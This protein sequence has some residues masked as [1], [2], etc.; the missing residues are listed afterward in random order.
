MPEII[1][2]RLHQLPIDEQQVELVERKGQGHPD[3]ICDGIANNASVALC[4]A[5]Q[6]AFGRI[7]HHNVDKLM[8][9]AGRS[10][11][12]IGGGT[13]DAPMKVIFGD[14]CSSGLDGRTIDVQ[15]IVFQ[16]AKE[17]L[18]SNLRF[19]DPDLHVVLQNEMKSGSSQLISLF[20]RPRIGANDTSAA[21]GFA[22]F[23]AT[24]SVVFE[25]ERYLNGPDFK[26]LFPE[27]GEDIKVM[28]FRHTRKLHLTIAIAFIGRFV[29][30]R[31]TYFKRKSEIVECLAAHL[32]AV[33]P[34]FDEI[35]IDINTLD[36]P[37]DE[38]GM[39][40]TVSGTSAE[41]SDS[42]EVGRGNRANG[43]ISFNRPQSIEAHAGKNPVNHVGK[44]YS[45]FATYAANRIY[46]Q[47]RGLREVY[48]QLCSQIGRPIDDPLA[49]SVK[50]ALAE[51]ASFNDVR[52]DA[53]NVF[54]EEL[55]GIVRFSASLATSDFYR[56]WEARLSS[57][58]K[59][60]D[61]AK[62]SATIRN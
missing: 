43:I 34:E 20:D 17:W 56:N 54:S 55:K 28:G 30:D 5:Y 62:P 31:E 27:T 46:S 29:P 52:R 18:R 60:G 49:S 39:Y 1:V 47:V 40:L 41:G 61:H 15:G 8:L 6:Q 11:P 38:T 45:Y 37:E 50:L 23:T 51:G 57:L 35:K 42:G 22:P 16:A 58:T 26:A 12:K 21:T 53:Q 7:L 9:V 36:N 2:E 32:N 3:S 48:V 44:I 19:V 10:T 4:E 33:R 25:L 13:I 24:E 59:Q 14:R